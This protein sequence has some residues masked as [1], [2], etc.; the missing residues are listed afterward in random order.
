MMKNPWDRPP[1]PDR[2]DPV[3]NHL[4]LA[5]GQALSAWEE[6]E[7]DLSW[8]YAALADLPLHSTVAYQ[9]YVDKADNF[10][11]RAIKLEKAAEQYFRRNPSQ[12]D[13]AEF[14]EIL[15]S[16]RGWATRRNDIAHGVVRPMPKIYDTTSGGDF[17]S[18]L[19][20]QD[21]YLLYPPDYAAKKFDDKTGAPAYALGVAELHWFAGMFRHIG[22]EAN[23]L[24]LRLVER[25]Q[26]T[27]T[28]RKHRGQ[29]PETKP[30]TPR[31][32]D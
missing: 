14:A 9:S 8:L 16:A 21:E 13:E 12:T 2:G 26:P 3:D 18:W 30:S 32:R 22:P 20:G 4:Y 28:R 23:R 15:R 27:P 17:E 31:S 1:I 6:Y 5:M 11:Q 29:H 7:I 10:K 25:R 19:R 24:T